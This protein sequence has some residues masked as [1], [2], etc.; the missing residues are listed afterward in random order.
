MRGRH[1]FDGWYSKAGFC[2][3]FSDQSFGSTIPYK[4][5]RKT[6]KSGTNRQVT[7]SVLKH[8]VPS[9]SVLVA[10]GKKTQSLPDARGY[11]MVDAATTAFKYHSP[12]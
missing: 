8:S 9:Q 4:W 3:N 7:S 10:G 1:L 6:K 11:A 12:R 2:L 5:R